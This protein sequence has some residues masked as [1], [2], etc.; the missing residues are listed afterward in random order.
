MLGAIVMFLGVG[1]GAF[2]AHGLSAHFAK[3]PHLEPT[4]ATAVRYH[5]IHG[6]ALLL[7]GLLAARWPGGWTQWSGYLLLAG[8]IIFSGSLYLLSLTGVR[9]LGAI[10]PIGGV[11]FLAGWICLFVAAWK[12]G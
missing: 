9:W 7:V 8:I 6:L 5:L 1:A 10:T 2:G 12:G 11:A 4:Y 3:F